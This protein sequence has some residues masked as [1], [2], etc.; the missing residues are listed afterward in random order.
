MSSFFIFNIACMARWDLAE[1][2]PLIISA[3]VYVAVC[4]DLNHN[5][6]LWFFA[7]WAIEGR[8]L[9][10]KKL[11]RFTREHVTDCL[12]GFSNTHISV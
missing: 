2:G 6:P 1:S 12:P 4:S 11:E 7:R 5:C 9:A 10:K 3:K 8:C